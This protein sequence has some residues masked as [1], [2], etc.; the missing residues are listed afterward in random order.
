LIDLGAESADRRRNVRKAIRTNTL[1]VRK[2]QVDTQDV[3]EPQ[4][5]RGAT[6]LRVG[7]CRPFGAKMFLV[8]GSWG[9]RPTITHIFVLDRLRSFPAKPVLAPCFSTGI[10]SATPNSSNPAEPLPPLRGGRG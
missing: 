1:G 10:V 4:R 7:I 3:D 6:H 9:L 5:A 2:P 8:I